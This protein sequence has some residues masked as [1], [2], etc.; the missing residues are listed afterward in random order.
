MAAPQNVIESDGPSTWLVESQG[1]L[2]VS[3]DELRYNRRKLM[4]QVELS[5]GGATTDFG[6]DSS[7]TAG[8]PPANRAESSNG[9]EV[10]NSS[11]MMVGNHGYLNYSGLPAR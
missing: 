3:Q 5:I 10:D 8:N 9:L 1:R 4:A 2:K 11:S 6:S 7:N